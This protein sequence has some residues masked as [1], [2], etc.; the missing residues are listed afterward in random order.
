MSIGT[1]MLEPNTQTRIDRNKI[2][3][4][5]VSPVSMMPDGLLNTLNREEVLDLVAY[6]MSRGDRNA[7]AYRKP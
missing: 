5:R 2:E 7:D 1:N 6:L 3:E 4:I